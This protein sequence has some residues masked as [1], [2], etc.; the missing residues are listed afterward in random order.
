MPAIVPLAWYGA[1][2]GL[3]LAIALILKKFNPVYSLFFGSIC[4]AI[5]G[6]ADLPQ[7][8]TMLTTGTQS[9]MGTVIRVLA[10]GILAG[11]MMESGAAET[12]ADT[13]V[14]KFGESKAIIALALA[15]MVITSIGVF[16]PVAVLI[17]APIALSVGN[18]IGASKIGLLLALSGGGKAGNIISPNP[19]AIAA[20]NGFH[21]SLSD[22]MIAGYSAAAV[23]L[24]ITIIIASIVK[25]KGIQ[26]ADHEVAQLGSHEMKKEL[27]NR[28]PAPA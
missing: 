27:R 7:I 17:V 8:V 26:V 6:G 16:I 25:H 14:K 18:K 23:G 2:F 1:L 11:V 4:G 10:A 28:S 19:N 5:I 20:A 3:F 9:V 15:T 12:I 24:I 13:I 22:V 21:I